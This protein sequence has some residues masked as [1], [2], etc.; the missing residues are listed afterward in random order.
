MP[1]GPVDRA[2][3]ASICSALLHRHL[4]P[5]SSGTSDRPSPAAPARCH[6][7]RFIQIFLPKHT[8][9]PFRTCNPRESE[10]PAVTK[11]LS[12]PP[13]FSRRPAA[14]SLSHATFPGSEWHGHQPSR[15]RG[16]ALASERSTLPCQMELFTSQKRKLAKLAKLACAIASHQTC[17]HANVISSIAS[18]DLIQIVSCSSGKA[19]ISS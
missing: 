9:R 5:S 1:H 2:H 14:C 18:P 11:A 19:Y 7:Q 13:D 16:P 4:A 8:M 6:S 17:V 12:P 10:C 15:V 3:R